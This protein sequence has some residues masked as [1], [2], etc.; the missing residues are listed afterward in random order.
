MCGARVI[1][2]LIFNPGGPRLGDLVTRV[3]LTP[4]WRQKPWRPIYPHRNSFNKSADQPLNEER[5][6]HGSAA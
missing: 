5:R 3:Q 1:F 6:Y 2:R 4:D